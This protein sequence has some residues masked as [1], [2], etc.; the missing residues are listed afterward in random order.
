MSIKPD[1]MVCFVLRTFFKLPF[2]A[3]EYKTDV[4]LFLRLP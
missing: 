4:S 2:T 3:S 1:C